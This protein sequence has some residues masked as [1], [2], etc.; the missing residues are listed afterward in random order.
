MENWTHNDKG[1]EE[2]QRGAGE[3]QDEGKPRLLRSHGAKLNNSARTV[4]DGDILLM[5]YAPMGAKGR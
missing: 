2:G 5:P 4:W 1:K 3:D